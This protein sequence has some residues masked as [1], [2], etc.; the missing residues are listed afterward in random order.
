MYLFDIHQASEN[1][2]FWSET[3]EHLNSAFICKKARR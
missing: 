2:K 3:D 1:E